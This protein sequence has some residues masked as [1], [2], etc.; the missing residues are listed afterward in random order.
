MPSSIPA[1]LYGTA[2]KGPR[3]TALVEQAVRAGFRG[4]DT[5]CQP[6]H[7]YQP[8]VGDALEALERDGVVKR[9]DLW[10]QT[11]YTPLPGQ[12][13]SKPLPYDPQAPLV[14]QASFSVRQSLATSLNELKT[15]Y[16][17]ALVLHSPMQTK[18]AHQE[19]WTEFE[20]AVDEG[21]VRQLGISN[22]YDATYLAWIFDTARIKPTIVQNRFYA[23]VGYG[24]HV[25]AL[26]AEHG[27]VFQSFWTL[28]GNPQLLAHPALHALA[29]A[30][31]SPD[32][33]AP[34]AL[35]E[36][37]MRSNAASGGARGRI[38]PLNGTTN[39]RRMKEAV[40]VV[41]RIEE[42][43]VS[44]DARRCEREVERLIWG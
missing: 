29:H 15:S 32:N 22:V 16:L 10:L 3:T 21:K 7:Y 41:R 27:D 13:T 28:T 1:M 26:C 2:W 23:D 39:E 30:Y 33:S 35:Y 34:A 9:E 42:E 36:F 20:R 8:G 19:V 38:I 11:K 17:D 18:Q 4:V 14:E 37:L 5:A 43:E 25:L 24:V 12:D 44:E 31:P 6:K 40:E